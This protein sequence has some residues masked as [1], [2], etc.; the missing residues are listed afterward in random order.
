MTGLYQSGSTCSNK[1]GQTYTSSYDGLGRSLGSITY[2]DASTIVLESSYSYTVAQ[3]VPGIS[4]D[5]STPFERTITL[6]AYNHQAIGFTDALGRTRY[7]Q[8]YSGIGSPTA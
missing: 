2:S 6:D 3:G 1:T 4:S 8:V 7:T 5:S